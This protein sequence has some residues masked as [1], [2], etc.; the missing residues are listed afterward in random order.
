MVWSCFAASEP[1]RL[2]DVIIAGTMN[3]V[4]YQK[5]L[6][7]NVWP[8]VHDLKVKCTWFMQQYS[9]LKHTSNSTSEWVKKRVL[10]WPI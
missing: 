7:E 5:I 8:S 3:S 10:Q 2:I 1:G 6:M 9:G 4:L